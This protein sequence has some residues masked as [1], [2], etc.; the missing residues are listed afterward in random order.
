MFFAV[1]CDACV[2]HC[3]CAL[4]VKRICDQILENVHNSHI[5]FFN[6]GDSYN[7]FGMTDKCETFRDCTTTIPLFI[8]PP[9]VSD[10]YT[11]CCGFY[12]SPNEQ[13]QTCELCMFF[14]IWSKFSHLA[15]LQLVGHASYHLA[16]Y[17]VII[18]VS[19]EQYLLCGYTYHS[20]IL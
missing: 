12:A 11:I 10:L 20:I 9:K 19:I 4:V 17:F 6:F 5:Q 7:L 14:Q 3:E 15:F 2:H 18:P 16:P 13:N 8:I 1:A